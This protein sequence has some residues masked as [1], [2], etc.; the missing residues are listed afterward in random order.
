VRPPGLVVV[1]EGRVEGRNAEDMSC[2]AEVG[3]GMDRTC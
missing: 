1:E 3:L 2:W